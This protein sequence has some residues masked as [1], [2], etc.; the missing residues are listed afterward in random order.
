MSGVLLCQTRPQSDLEISP[1]RIRSAA[2]IQRKIFT[3][4]VSKIGRPAPDVATIHL[5]LPIG[6]RA[7]FRAG[8]YLR[9]LMGNGVSRNYSMANAPQ[10]N[11]KVEL[12][13]R[14]VPGGKFSEDVLARLEKAS[15]LDIELPYGEFT[16]SDERD[17]P[18]ILIATGTGFA[19]MKSMI[20]NNIRLGSK[21]PLHLYWGAN[22]ESDLYMHD[23]VRNWAETYAW[24]SYTPVVS[25]PSAQW[26]GRTGF[27]HRAVQVD[28]P[29][30]SGL[31]VYACGA[32]IMIES[33]QRDFRAESALRE[34]AFF[35]DAFVPS[36]DGDVSPAA[37]A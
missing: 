6:Q 28:H 27:V 30:M 9:V 37:V 21:R 33:A 13:I 35:S 8:Q 5:R 29:D 7:I 25:N 18:A 11:D 10:N 19:P 23:M 15:T 12:H 32:P 4:K 1:V 36:G 16:L 17:W 22:A 26:S 31:E 34:D 2:M 3:A 14:H 20:E 24:F